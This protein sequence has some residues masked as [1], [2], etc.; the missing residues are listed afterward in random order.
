MNSDERFPSAASKWVVVILVS[1]LTAACVS[2]LVC[3]HGSP[4]QDRSAESRDRGAETRD[5]SAKAR[6]TWTNNWAIVNDSVPHLGAAG[7]S[8]TNRAKYIAR[9]QSL[10]LA[11]D[12]ALQALRERLVASAR[13]APSYDGGLYDMVVTDA[14]DADFDELRRQV[15]KKV[16][17]HEA[18]TNERPHPDHRAD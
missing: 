9:L 2:W 16:F 1:G 15:R 4:A 13:N 8:A 10:D 7:I 11:D 12:A 14:I 17:E 6:I 5:R 18:T 3:R